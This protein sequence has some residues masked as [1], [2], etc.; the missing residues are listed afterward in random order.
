MGTV[1]YNPFVPAKVFTNLFDEFLNRGLGDFVGA[2]SMFTQPSVNVLETKDNFQIELAAPGL[3]KGD[4]EVKLD[5]G[6][7]TISAK[8]ENKEE[9]TEG[10]YTRK[11]F[12]FASFTRSFQL[13]D[14]IN[15]ADIAATYENGV[16]LV[17]LPKKEEAKVVAARTVEIG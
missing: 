2:D 1:K 17:T 4:F 7:L 3:A 15:A 8:K 12:N 6:T 13:P 11:E 9:T 5:N 16:L 14:T 10:K